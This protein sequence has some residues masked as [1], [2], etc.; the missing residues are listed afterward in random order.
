MLIKKL[1]TPFDP[2]SPLQFFQ[3]AIL[4]DQTSCAPPPPLLQSRSLLSTLIIS[5]ENRIESRGGYANT[6]ESVAPGDISA[7]NTTW[8]HSDRIKDSVPTRR[9]GLPF[10]TPLSSFPR[11]WSR[12]FPASGNLSNRKLKR[13]P[14]LSSY[15]FTFRA[16]LSPLRFYPP[17]IKSVWI[18]RGQQWT[19]I[20]SDWCCSNYITNS[21]DSKFENWWMN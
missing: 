1:E 21:C 3:S 5:L 18:K 11:V 12:V 9:R 17:T 4:D 20:S 10:A 2:H 19:E 16:L 13:E 7:C 15:F 8:L 6:I 14:R